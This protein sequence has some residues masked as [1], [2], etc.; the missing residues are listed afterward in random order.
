MVLILFI[1]IFLGCKKFFMF[2]KKCFKN[3]F[4]VCFIV[5]NMVVI[6]LGSCFAGERQGTNLLDK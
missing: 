2:F 6:C 1:V 5:F 4:D 3:V